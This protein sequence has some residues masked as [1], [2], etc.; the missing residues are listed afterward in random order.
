M[1][2]Q[3]DTSK[4]TSQNSEE[5]SKKNYVTKV[6]DNFFRCVLILTAV[7]SLAQVYNCCKAKERQDKILEVLSDSETTLNSHDR[8]VINYSDSSVVDSNF[9]NKRN[10]LQS[11]KKDTIVFLEK[12][13]KDPELNTSPNITSTIENIEKL[14]HLEI[15]KIEEERTSLTL[16]IG[17][18]TVV[19]LIFSF[20]SL[21]KSDEFVKTSK[22][23][24]N[25]IRKI[26]L[27]SVDTKQRIDNVLKKCSKNLNSFK[28]KYEKKY[29]NLYVENEKRFDD[30]YKDI[31]QINSGYESCLEQIRNDINQ[32]TENLKNTLAIA[33]TT[34]TEKQNKDIQ[35]SLSVINNDFNGESPYKNK[36][37]QSREKHTNI[38]TD[39]K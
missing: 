35:E 14:L 24:M 9:L 8:D 32:L 19:F 33:K 39:K 11:S 22:E 6:S 23:S 10:S 13:N 18:M 28:F 1:C 34:L 3:K 26:E 27:T 5:I 29:T 7:F 37:T 16:W 17:I 2:N 36:S 4:N 20:Y 12:E 30:K 21:I 31:D 38:D 25:E 15:A